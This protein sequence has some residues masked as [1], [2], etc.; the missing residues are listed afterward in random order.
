M[1]PAVTP[2]AMQEMREL[3]WI[4]LATLSTKC[5]LLLLLFHKPTHRIAL[6]LG[7]NQTV[8]PQMPPAQTANA[9]KDMVIA[10]LSC[11]RRFTYLRKISNY[12]YMQILSEVSMSQASTPDSFLLPD[13]R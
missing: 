8:Y 10:L 7:F 3:S 9:S 4:A 11:R 12:Q 6:L 2:P 13:D 5:V 1:P